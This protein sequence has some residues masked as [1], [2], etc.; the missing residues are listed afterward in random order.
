MI[1]ATDAAVTDAIIVDAGS[2]GSKVYAYMW[3][4]P[5]GDAPAIA[6]VVQVPEKIGDHTNLT[7]WPFTIDH[8]ACA[9]GAYCKLDIP[10]NE[11]MYMGRPVSLIVIL[12]L[13]DPG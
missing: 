3:R 6:N 9:V 2:S 10:V 5:A 8:N 13:L 4:T 12:L 7:P 1:V 11:G